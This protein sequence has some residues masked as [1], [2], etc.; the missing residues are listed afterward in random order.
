M[1]GNTITI[2]IEWRNKR[3]YSLLARSAWRLGVCLP[4]WVTRRGTI[5]EVVK[6]DLP[7]LPEASIFHAEPEPGES[8]TVRAANIRRLFDRLT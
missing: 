5:I 6:S 3:W 7:P 2:E 1:A 8:S 4:G